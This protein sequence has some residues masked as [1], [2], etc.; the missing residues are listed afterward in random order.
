M[1][2]ISLT[3]PR[4]R[5]S[6]ARA[7]QAMNCPIH[8]IEMAV[9]KTR[10]GPRHDCHAD[11]CTVVWWSDSPTSTPAD[12]ETRAARKAAH[13]AFDPLWQ[14]QGGRFHRRRT[15]AY[16]WLAKVLGVPGHEAHIGMSNKEQ[17]EKLLAAIRELELQET[18]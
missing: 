1:T 14:H 13:A 6:G 5:E 4:V 17:C 7:L 15:G 10:Y 8:N 3:N 11:G 16:R 12:A 18:R 9:T 2:C